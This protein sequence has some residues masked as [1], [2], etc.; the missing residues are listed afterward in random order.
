MLLVAVCLTCGF[1][2]PFFSPK[3]DRAFAI[4]CI[5]ATIFARTRK[6]R[7]GLRVSIILLL[8]VRYV[9]YVKQI[10]IHDRDLWLLRNVIRARCR[11]V[12]RKIIRVFDEKKYLL[13][14]KFCFMNNLTIFFFC[15]TL[16]MEK[17]ENWNQFWRYACADACVWKYIWP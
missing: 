12:G 7:A 6:R 13:Y 3:E 10:L 4:C 1:F 8:L 14:E 2:L 16:F 5:A 11:R 15:N 9:V 17:I